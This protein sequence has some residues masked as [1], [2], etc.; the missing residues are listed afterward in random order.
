LY[1]ICYHFLKSDTG[2]RLYDHPYTLILDDLV[3]YIHKKDGVG[4]DCFVNDLS[5]VILNI[6]DYFGEHINLSDYARSTDNLLHNKIWKVKRSAN[7]NHFFYYD[8]KTADYFDPMGRSIIEY[9]GNQ[10]I[11]CSDW[12]LKPVM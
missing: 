7:F 9:M 1:V 8:A 6:G 10:L 12:K 11:Y 2:K 5:K 3:E 4:K